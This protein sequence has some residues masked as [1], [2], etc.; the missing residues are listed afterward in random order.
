M[1]DVAVATVYL[2]AEVLEN[3]CVHNNP[4]IAMSITASISIHLYILSVN[5]VR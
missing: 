3:T 4:S 1:L 5:L 2:L